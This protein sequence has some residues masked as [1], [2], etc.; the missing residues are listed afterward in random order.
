[1]GPARRREQRV[2]R[3][4]MPPALTQRAPQNQEANGQG[5]PIRTDGSRQHHDPQAPRHQSS[6]PADAIAPPQASHMQQPAPEGGPGRTGESKGHE[7]PHPPQGRHAKDAGRAPRSATN[8][9]PPPPPPRTGSG[10]DRSPQPAAA[11]P[12]QPDTDPDKR[13]SCLRPCVATGARVPQPGRTSA[14]IPA[15]IPPGPHPGSPGSGGPPPPPGEGEGRGG[16]GRQEQRQ[17]EGNEAGRDGG[18]IGEPTHPKPQCRPERTGETSRHPPQDPTRARRASRPGGQWK[19]HRKHPPR[20]EGPEPSRP[21]PAR[22]QPQ[23][24]EGKDTSSAC[25]RS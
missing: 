19:K 2:R 3:V 25:T 5:G 7:P 24:E 17:E 21:R 4:V 6:I 1:M 10:P 23:G 16:A 12:R 22:R 9:P 14:P 8:P 13:G 20:G 11:E 18:A 15:N